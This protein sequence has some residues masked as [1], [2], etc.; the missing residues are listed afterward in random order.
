[1]EPARLV[2][3][4]SAKLSELLAASPAQ[5]IE[6][7]VKALVASAFERLELATREELDVQAKVLART[8]EKLA[9]LE[10]RVAELERELRSGG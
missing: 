3:E 8:R 6:R 1:M 4:V 7:N 2:D 5:D 9:A 10:T